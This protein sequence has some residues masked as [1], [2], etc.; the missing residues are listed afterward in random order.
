MTLAIILVLAAA[1]GYVLWR[2]SLRAH[3]YARCLWC[4][5]RRGRN[6]GSGRK[7]LGEVWGNCKHCGGS[8][9]RL[10]LGAKGK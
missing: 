7:V 8:G 4:R 5:D 10:R 2:L 9:R 1:G 6:R 3:P